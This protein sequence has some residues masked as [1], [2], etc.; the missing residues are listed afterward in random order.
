[1]LLWHSRCAMAWHAL[2]IQYLLGKHQQANA[3]SI[4]KVMTENVFLVPGVGTTHILVCN[5]LFSLTDLTRKTLD[6]WATYLVF[7]EYCL[8]EFGSFI[9]F[10]LL[11]IRQS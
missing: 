4:E 10:S 8:D 1:M 2:P 6:V 5:K 9:E 3:R 7:P 11:M